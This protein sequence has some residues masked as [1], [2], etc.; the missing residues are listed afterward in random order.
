MKFMKPI[1]FVDFNGVISYQ[2]FWNSIYAEDHK[3]FKLRNDINSFV[4]V[5]NK[6]FVKDWMIGLHTAE[7]AHK[8][9]KEKFDIDRDY[10]FEIFKR[11]AETIDVSEK[12][13]RRLQELRSKYKVVLITDNMDTFTRFTLP[14]NPELSRTF[15]GIFVSFHTGKLKKT[16]EGK[17]FKNIVNLFDSKL[18]KSILIDDSK[19]NCELFESIGGQSICVTGENEVLEELDKI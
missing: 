4:F 12:I 16:G 1:L 13:L 15:D 17:I 14:N 9:I 18:G 7:E 19:S 3:L 10:L 11:D 5:E 6:D 8:L 2:N